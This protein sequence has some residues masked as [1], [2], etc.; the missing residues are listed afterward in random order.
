MLKASAASA[1]GMVFA[2]P[3]RAAAPP[4]TEVTSALVEAA[5]REGKVSFYSALELTTAERLSRMF[6]AK[7]S[8]IAVRVE[9]S[10]A[11][12]IFQRIA[13]EQG[14]GIHAVDVA[15]STD[16]AH[17]LDW[18][19]HGWLA[20]YVPD[21]VAKHFP[22]DHRSLVGLTG[23]PDEIRKVAN[24]YKA[25]YVKVQHERSRD[26]SIDHAGVIYLIGRNGEYLGFMP[27]QTNP[28]RLT[29]VLRRNLGNQQMP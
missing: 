29:E 17:Y 8:G 11:E 14:S 4:P 16:P 2:E 3:L 23:S 22:A 10:G 7:Y 1:V 26:Y 6:E 19:K 5:R 18:K 21:D 27:P 25:F 24:S 15:N 28:D 12:R 20:P 9:R 13:Q